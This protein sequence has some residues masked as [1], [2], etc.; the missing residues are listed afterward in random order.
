MRDNYL[1]GLANRLRALREQR[2]LT[3]ADVGRQ[4][5]KDIH[6]PGR[7]LRMYETELRSPSAAL[8]ID[9][10]LFYGVSTD[11]LLGIAPCACA[12]NGKKAS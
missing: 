4:M 10:A 9:L 12:A 8:L 3:Q 7:R 5:G 2:G 6:D 11:Y 1:P